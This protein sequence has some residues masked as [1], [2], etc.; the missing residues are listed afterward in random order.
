MK[1]VKT[2]EM[3]K[4]W[5]EIEPYVT[6]SVEGYDIIEEAPE[7]IKE[8]LIEYEHLSKEQHDFAEFIEYGEPIGMSDKEKELF[9]IF[10]PYWHY[11]AE[12]ERATIALEAPKKVKIAY[13]EYF[14]I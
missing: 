10:S 12:L 6:W 3:Q 7:N 5:D 9:V 1:L 14:K 8:K 4:I 11:D 13:E 2:P